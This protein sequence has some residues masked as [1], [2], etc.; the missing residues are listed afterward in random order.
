MYSSTDDGNFKQ[1]R[2]VRVGT[3]ASSEISTFEWTVLQDEI[4]RDSS[5][6]GNTGMDD[7][8]NCST[9]EY[10]RVGHSFLCQNDVE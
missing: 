6:T 7:M 2:V 10:M 5:I 9:L 1:D 4:I 8:K 3:A